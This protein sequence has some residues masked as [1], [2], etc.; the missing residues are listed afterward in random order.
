MNK[1]QTFGLIFI[2]CVLL[3]FLVMGG[4]LGATPT[5]SLVTNVEF[6]YELHLRLNTLK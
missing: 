6:E 4:G 1:L 5:Y 2:S 3:G